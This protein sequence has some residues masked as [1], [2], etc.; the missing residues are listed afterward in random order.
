[1]KTKLEILFWQVAIKILERKYFSILSIVG[2]Y[3]MRYEAKC[4]INFIKEHIELL[5]S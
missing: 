4:T 3:E 2:R 1:M 5:K